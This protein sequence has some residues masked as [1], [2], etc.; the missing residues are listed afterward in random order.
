MALMLLEFFRSN[1]RARFKT[2]LNFPDR[3]DRILPKVISGMFMLAYG[4]ERSEQ[5]VLPV[6]GSRN[7]Q[8]LSD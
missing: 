1:Q 6:R 2:D 5:G 3:F 8:F 7:I 4:W